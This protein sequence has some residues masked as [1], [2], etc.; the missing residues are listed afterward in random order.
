VRARDEDPDSGPASPLTVLLV[1]DPLAPVG[2]D[3]LGGAEQILS[4]LD[5]ALVASGHRSIVIAPDGSVCRGRLVATP[6]PRAPRDDAALRRASLWH[7]ATITR[8]LR[9]HAI[10]VVHLHG[11][12]FER[13]LPGAGPPVLVT[14]H[15]PATFYAPSVFRLER[16]ATFLHGVSASQTAELPEDAFLLPPIVGGVALDR[17]AVRAHKQ[18]FALALGRVCPEKGYHLALAAAARARV[19]LLLAGGVY[20]SV[21]HE[22]YFREAIAPRLGGGAWFLGPIGGARKRRLLAGARCLLVPSLV[23][24]A[25]SLVAM[26]ALASGT[27]VI[28]FRRGALP[29]MVEHGATGFLVDDVEEMA[30][31]IRAAESID[32][33]A[34]RRAAEE[35]FAAGRMTRAYVETYAR[36]IRAARCASRITARIDPRGRAAGE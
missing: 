15:R 30:D 23:A 12:D 11:A 18:G 5:E 8:A 36:V 34:C 35:R 16:P 31:A 20:P 25:S 9:D 2:P 7:R 6:L 27:P 26:E 19:G 1:G 29:E 4:L 28:A 17:A 22:R 24:E 3:A 13:H 10:D 14:L 21:A 32:P 33:L